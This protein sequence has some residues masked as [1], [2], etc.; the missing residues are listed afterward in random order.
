VDDDGPS[1]SPELERA[2]ADRGGGS[3]SV[4]AIRFTRALKTTTR[5]L[6]EKILT[7]LVDVHWC[8]GT[9][10]SGPLRYYCIGRPL[11]RLVVDMRGWGQGDDGQ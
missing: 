9:V 11:A 7:C 8:M 5:F 2:A 10:G 3:V 6:C 1:S 4:S